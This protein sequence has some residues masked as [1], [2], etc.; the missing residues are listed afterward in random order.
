MEFLLILNEKLPDVYNRIDD[1]LI[2]INYHP[3]DLIKDDN[4]TNN[5]NDLD[6]IFASSTE[7]DLNIASSYSTSSEILKKNP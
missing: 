6:D 1:F 3:V 2:N 4:S 5:T 7:T